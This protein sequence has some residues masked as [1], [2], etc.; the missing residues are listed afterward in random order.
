A[1][2][3]DSDYRPFFYAWWQH[4]AY[5]GSLIG[6]PPV[7][8]GYT[9][10]ERVLMRAL[11]VDEDQLAWRR[12]KIQD[13]NGDLLSFHQE[14]PSQPEEAFLS[15]GTNVFQQDLL[16]SV[17]APQVGYQGVISVTRRGREFVR[18]SEGPLTV[19]KAPAPNR[20]RGQY[21]I[22]ADPSGSIHGDYAVAQVFN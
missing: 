13:L 6:E 21:I 3:G 22:G 20:Q 1:E 7:L 5:R 17:Y 14:Y 12:W 8:R 18:T 4:P 9:E 2:S 11:G 19:F 10:D 16:R 15:T